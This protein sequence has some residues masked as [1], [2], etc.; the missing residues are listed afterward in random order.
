MNL[1]ELS[2]MSQCQITVQFEMSLKA[3]N[4]TT[5]SKKGWFSQVPKKGKVKNMMFIE[6]GVPNK[7][8]EEKNHYNGIKN[9]S[10][11]LL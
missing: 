6:K 11:G 1:H 8:C 7:K 9:L 10:V 5:T 4:S 3:V 2:I